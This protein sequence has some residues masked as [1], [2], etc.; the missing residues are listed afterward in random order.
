MFSFQIIA[1]DLLLGQGPEF[2]EL[3]ILPTRLVT[4]PY[5]MSGELR[6]RSQERSQGPVVQSTIKLI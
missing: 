3:S 5:D 6:S 1:G 2:V 4:F